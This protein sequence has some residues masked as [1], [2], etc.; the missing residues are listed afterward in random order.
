MYNTHACTYTSR[1]IVLYSL[2]DLIFRTEV[3]FITTALSRKS[4]NGQ[5]VG[6]VLCQQ[7]AAGN[8]IK[9]NQFV[10]IVVPILILLSHRVKSLV[11]PLIHLFFI[12]TNYYIYLLYK[13]K[14]IDYIKTICK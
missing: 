3:I 8:R 7:R 4:R 9:H 1:N 6:I 2:S 5:K 14:C 11:I 12:S 10:K 13:N